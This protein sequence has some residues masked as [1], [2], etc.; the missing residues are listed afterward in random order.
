[1]GKCRVATDVTCYRIKGDMLDKWTLYHRLGQEVSWTAES[2]AVENSTSE[3]SD[4]SSWL[5]LDNECPS[6]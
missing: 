6:T 1:M 4:R 2:L 3:I 5:S